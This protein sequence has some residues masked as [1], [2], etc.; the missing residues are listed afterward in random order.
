MSDLGISQNGV[1]KSEPEFSPTFFHDVINVL[2]IA[3]GKAK[4]A[5]KLLNS[6][7][8]PAEPEKLAPVIEK[9]ES[10][11]TAL[12]R[13]QDQIEVEAKIA[14]AKKSDRNAA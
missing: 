3:L 14:R 7:V 12:K 8:N 5:H 11:L 1:Q 2:A 9:L 13:M 10:T 6:L 4:Q